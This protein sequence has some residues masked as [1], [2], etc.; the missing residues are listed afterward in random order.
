[1]T[2]LT[3]FPAEGLR[4]AQYAGLK[5]GD[6]VVHFADSFTQAWVSVLEEF[7][8]NTSEWWTSKREHF[9]YDARS[10]AW[11]SEG[12][13]ETA[14][15]EFRALSPWHAQES[16]HAIYT[17]LNMTDRDASVSAF[18]AHL[19]GLGYEPQVEKFAD[20]TIVITVPGGRVQVTADGQSLVE[21]V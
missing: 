8:Q 3:V 9:R 7:G 2:A 5:V 4:P 10:G 21:A 1:M 6:K 19:E 15:P 14:T 18:V 11:V 20:N 16:G 12:I 13:V 17:A